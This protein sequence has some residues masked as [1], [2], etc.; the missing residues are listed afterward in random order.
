[1]LKGR[2]LIMIFERFVGPKQKASVTQ[3]AR[4]QVRTPD[5]R[6]YDIKGVDLV[7]NKLIGARETHRIVISTHEEVAKMGKPKLIV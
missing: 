7:E 5:G 1:M 2:D 6:H 3:D 4:V